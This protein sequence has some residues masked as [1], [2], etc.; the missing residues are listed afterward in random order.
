[1]EYQQA[2]LTAKNLNESCPYALPIELKVVREL[3]DKLTANHNIVM[4]GAGPGVFALAMLEGRRNPPHLHIVDIDTCDWAQ[5]H[6]EAADCN[7]NQISFIVG[8]SPDVGRNWQ[9][10]VDLLVVD[11]DHTFAGVS[12]DLAAWLSHVPA[13]SFVFLHDYLERPGGMDGIEEWRKGGVAQ[14]VEDAV[15]AGYL[16]AERLVGISCV[17]RRTNK[18]VGA[19]WEN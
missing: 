2:P 12:A 10:R 17:C 15:T 6:L 19:S 11:G 18:T 8:N 16:V 7:L 1:M 3:A 5:R 9:G 4:V 14:A 13:G